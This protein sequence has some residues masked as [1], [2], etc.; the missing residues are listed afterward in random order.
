[1]RIGFIDTG[2]K[3]FT[4]MPHI[5]IAALTAVLKAAGHEVRVLDLFYAT[6]FDLV[7]ISST[8]FSFVTAAQ[9]FPDYSVFDMERY[10]SIPALKEYAP[11]VPVIVDPS[12]ATF[13]RSY[14]APMP[15]AAIAAR[16]DGLLIEVYPTPDK[17][18]VDP[19]NAVSF[20]DFKN[21]VQE[22][23][24]IRRIIHRS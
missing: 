15:P 18:W 6:S 8:S 22:L 3:S 9:P 4:L 13:K 10:G 17:A 12:H 20:T 5:G 2:D 24:A 11:S 19:L 21:L 16:A 7:G 23:D 14:V 1:M